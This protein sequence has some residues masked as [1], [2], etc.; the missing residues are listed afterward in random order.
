MAPWSSFARPSAWAFSDH[1]QQAQPVELG[2][3]VVEPLQIN[4]QLGG[5]LGNASRLPSELQQD[6]AQMRLGEDR[7]SAGIANGELP[8]PRIVLHVE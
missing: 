7:R 5:N 3:G 6:P 2:H 1:L 4:G 8:T